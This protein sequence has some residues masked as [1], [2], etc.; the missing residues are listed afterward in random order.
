[1]R[2]TQGELRKKV[3]PDDP[4]VAEFVEWA[5]ANENELWLNYLVNK[6]LNAHLAKYMSASPFPRGTPIDARVLNLIHKFWPALTSVEVGDFRWAVMGHIHE[7]GLIKKAFP[8][9]QEP[10]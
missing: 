8:E 10:K 4:R 5:N 3:K 2:T 6:G 1:M 7:N 9:Y